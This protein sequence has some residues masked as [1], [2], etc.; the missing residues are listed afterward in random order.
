MRTIATAGLLV[1]LAAWAGDVGAPAP[2]AAKG[3]GPAAK[4]PEKAKAAK[5]AADAGAQV[6][7]AKGPAQPSG[8]A[9]GESAA[10]PVLLIT[11]TGDALDKLEQV[12]PKDRAAF[13]GLVTKM[14]IG[15]HYTAG[16]FVDG[17]TLPRSRRVG[18]AADISITAPNGDVMVE[19]VSAATART[20]DPKLPTVYLKPSLPI[21]WGLTDQE[22]EYTFRVKLYDEVRGESSVKVTRVTV[23][24]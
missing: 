18:L 6:A 19:R 10:T 7:T 1:A 22:G 12:A 20:I 5:G 2:E 14:V 15:K 11:E 8:P 23:V 9:A 17:Y 4:T 21:V 24:R 16:I 3:P 13:K